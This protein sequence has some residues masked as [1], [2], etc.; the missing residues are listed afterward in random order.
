MNCKSGFLQ[1]KLPE[2]DKKKTPF[3]TP[4]GQ[5]QF[6]SLP[7]GLANSPASFQRLMDVVLNELT[8]AECWIFLDYVIIY[9]DTVEEHAR[10]LEHVLQRFEK[11]NILLQQSAFLRY[12]R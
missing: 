9:S 4:S 11:A 8:G 7:F 5:Y 2:E 1:V 6:Q 12:Q 10:R 3:T